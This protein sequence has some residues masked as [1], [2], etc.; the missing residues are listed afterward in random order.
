M[1]AFPQKAREQM[2]IKQEAG[3]T[4]RGKR[5]REGSMT[6]N[7]LQESNL[8]RIYTHV[9]KHTF[10]IQT[11]FRAEY[12][13]KENRAR[14]QVLKAAVTKA[15]YGFI[16]IKGWS[17]ENLGMSSETR[18]VEESIVIIGPV[19][20]DGGQFKTF[21]TNRGI[22]DDQ[23][24]ILFVPL[25]EKIAYLI[26][27]KDFDSQG[28]K[29]YPGLGVEVRIGEW[30]PNKI[31]DFYSQLKNGRTFIFESF[32]EEPGNL[33]KYARKLLGIAD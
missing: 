30:H 31:G 11:A 6:M 33:G 22:D 29:V 18:V 20:P 3:T 28:N 19:K 13:L 8:S 4:A 2:K 26:G 16:N 24:A 32:I 12:T 21:V 10:S 7:N 9:E 23:D 27:T 17:V 25:N 1:N 14:N 15:G 5:I